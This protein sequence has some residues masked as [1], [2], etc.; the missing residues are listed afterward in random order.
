MRARALLAGAVMGVCAALPCASSGAESGEGPSP[1][2]KLETQWRSWGAW[3]EP[4]PG[5]RA[6]FFPIGDIFAPP[7]ADQKQPR[8]FA[9]WQ[10]YRTD[11][12]SYKVGSVGFGENVG[13]VRRLGAREGEGWQIGVSGGVF[14]VFNLD[15]ESHDLLNADYVIGFPLSFRR[16]RWSARARLY[17]QSSHL[18]DEFLLTS[19]PIAVE[20]INL[21][22]EVLEALVSWDSK[23]LR[24][25]GGP[26][27]ILSTVTPL[28][29]QRIQ[30]GVEH[31][32]RD[33]AILGGRLIAG[34]EWSAWQETAWIGS[35]G[36]KTGLLF[37]SPY[38]EARSVR[39]FAEY[40]TGQIPHGQFYRL[41]T[42]YFGFGFAFSL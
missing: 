18:G 6:V 31:L 34:I 24:V 26:S 5:R 25:Y 12:G 10:A 28:K 36:V 11:F 33:A 39:L 22:F 32:G 21:S 40:Y 41:R 17:H 3:K 42:R 37:S 9:S 23:Q 1:R 20:R 7:L 27:R 38:Q 29:R 30:A 4:R 35:L 2:G 16:G 19:Q 14:A 8:F 13:L 15:A